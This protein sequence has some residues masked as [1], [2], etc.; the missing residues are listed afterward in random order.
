MSSTGYQVLTAKEIIGLL[1]EEV[2]SRDAKKSCK[3]LNE[4]IVNLSP[5]VSDRLSI[6]Q[7][8]GSK[9]YTSRRDR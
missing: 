6:L 8:N 1:P 7:L 4:E 2:F 9:R 3:K 5:L